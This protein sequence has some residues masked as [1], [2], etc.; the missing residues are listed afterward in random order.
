M[1]D[2]FFEELDKEL[3]NRSEPITDPKLRY[4]ILRGMAR[5]FYDL[6]EVTESPGFA[7]DLSD[8]EFWDNFRGSIESIDRLSWRLLEGIRDPDSPELP[9]RLDIGNSNDP[10]EP[11]RDPEE[12]I[13]GLVALRFYVRYILETIAE[14][15]LSLMIDSPYS[16]EIIQM[17]EEA[18]LGLGILVLRLGD[19]L[20]AENE[21]L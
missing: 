6:L 9:E 8:P 2:Q 18:F 7:E 5:F 4:G 17:L 20:E 12:R 10:E 15:D 19:G 16:A 14:G 3:G 1:I 21:L 13:A 11:I